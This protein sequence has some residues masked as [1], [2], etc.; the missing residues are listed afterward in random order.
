[1]LI[2]PGPKR[3]I[4]I[5]AGR[6]DYAEVVLGS[7][8][9]LVGPNNVGK[10]SLIAT[11]QFLYVAAFSE[12]KFS[13]PW[14]ESQ[15]YY[16]QD[17]TSTILFET[18][19]SDGR[20]VTL[21]LRGR[22][23]LGGYQVDRFAFEGPYG[24]DDFLSKDNRARDFA[25]VKARL[26]GDRYF[27]MLD[28]ADIRA[29]VVGDYE[30]VPALNMGI[31]PLKNP[32]RY[33]DFVYLLKN[34]LRLNNLSQKDIK[35]TLLNVYR[36]DIQTVEIDL[37]GTYADLHAKLRAERTKLDNL[38]KVALLAT[39]LKVNRAARDRARRDL[40]AM[41]VTLVGSK[42][43][44]LTA[45]QESVKD[46]H[47]QTRELDVADQTATT[48][49]EELEAQNIKIVQ[50]L[51]RATDW[52]DKVDKEGVAL[53]DYLPDMAAQERKNLAVEFDLLT[54]KIVQPGDPIALERALNALAVSLQRTIEQ[55]N[56]HAN[57]LG[58]RLQDHLGTDA[59]ADL[60]RIFHPAILR[61]PVESGVID[62]K[63]EEMLVTTL[64]RLHGHVEHGRLRAAGIEVTLDRVAGADSVA[65]ADIATLNAEIGALE[66]S[67][68]EATEALETARNMA[69]LKEAREALKVLL[70]TADTTAMR[71]EQWQ[72]DIKLVPAKRKECKE[73]EMAQKTNLNARNAMS[74]EAKERVASRSAITR[75]LEDLEV[76][77]RE[78]S[79]IRPIPVDATW[80][81]G[82]VDPEWP[83]MDA[84]DIN[85]LY[86][87]THNR[88]IEA[89][90]E[91]ARVLDEAEVV[92]QDGFPGADQ[93]AR[94]DALVEA[95]DSLA[96]HEQSFRDQLGF[97]IKGMHA[98][99]NNMF[100]AYK[101]LLDCVNDFNRSIGKV[102]I[103]NLSQLA[104]EI[105]E[106]TEV[107]KHY[108]NVATSDLLDEP[109]KTE[110]A[111][112]AIAN[113]I[114][115]TRV[116]RLSD[117]FGVRF[118][119]TT[120]NGETKGYDDLTVMESNG[121]TMAIKILVNIVLIRAM[122]R[123]KKPF[124]VPFYID[125]ATQIDEANLREIVALANDKGF[126]P[127]L[128]ST[129]PASVAEHIDFVRRVGS[130]RAVIDPKWRITRQAKLS[131]AD[132]A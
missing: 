102:S 80:P 71:Y 127:V 59:I 49:Q 74:E 70:Q 103:S 7:S 93:D 54:A 110:E 115:N 116:L 66:L 43:R 63:D 76:R 67:V 81:L 12:M 79:S 45:L 15:R 128:A 124:M 85:S 132:A 31:V 22:G 51:T 14:E 69:N 40:P 84:R 112:E 92:Y 39:S 101:D 87:Q 47:R 2:T 3:L 44:A 117:W 73:L 60:G 13:R 86:V 75:S 82:A 28:P 95:V 4:L 24:R 104:I 9:H 107:T 105:Y 34:L 111:I 90:A 94:I 89:D 114:D 23:Q 118:V 5:R 62:I 130:N 1:M 91:V 131:H 33:S 99:F 109:G 20:F 122:M 98:S 16:F 6:Y 61:L 26:V 11:L 120:A 27:K 55:R 78:L 19:T 46:A 108:R 88:Y 126:C 42:A 35:D 119:I 50:D 56:K 106:N 96:E 36:H 97:V 125:E 30:A 10:T 57:L 64:E 52:I 58:T 48:Q 29:A 8:T 113:T 53:R 32:A 65:V 100:K 121:T 41:Y 77:Q 129:V 17:D 25:E 37:H 21:G 38:R 83:E 123:K 18:A 68:K 72:Q